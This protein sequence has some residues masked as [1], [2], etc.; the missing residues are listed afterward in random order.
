M[1][2]QSTACT[3]S[4][5][6]K[7]NNQQHVHTV[8]KKTQQS[9]ACTQFAHNSIQLNAA[10]CSNTYTH[11]LCLLGVRHPLWLHY[12]SQWMDGLWF[13]T[14][15]RRVSGSL[16]TSSLV[17]VISPRVPQ[18]GRMLARNSVHVM[19]RPATALDTMLLLKDHFFWS[20]SNHTA[21]FLAT[22]LVPGL[23]VLYSPTTL[24]SSNQTACSQSRQLVCLC[25][26][27]NS[28]G[29]AHRQIW[30]QAIPVLNSLKR[31]CQEKLWKIREIKPASVKLEKR[32]LSEIFGRRW[33]ELRRSLEGEREGG[34]DI[35]KKRERGCEL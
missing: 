25:C 33:R 31:G 20:T 14:V 28:Y 18:Q 5:T 2:C 13:Y 24:W 34:G 10:E 30:G 27:A 35:W 23:F 29:G 1:V 21:C 9:T 19:P 8:M 6:K 15:S 16:S 11:T 22:Q 26:I 4:H 3:H 17:I 12:A 7:H 32:E